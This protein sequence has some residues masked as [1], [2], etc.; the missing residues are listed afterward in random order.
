ME[1]SELSVQELSNRTGKS[2]QSIYKRIRNKNDMIQS[3]LKRDNEGNILEPV[4]IFESAID[5]IYNKGA[6]SSKLN[7]KPSLV[8]FRQ[9]EEKTESKQEQNAY[10]KAIDVL[11]DQL[12][13]LQNE[14]QAEREDKQQKDRLIFELNERLA[15]SQRNLD[16]QQKLQ[17]IDRQRIKELEETNEEI[18]TKQLQ[19]LQELREIQELKKPLYKRLLD[20]F[21]KKGEQEQ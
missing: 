11:Q 17:L 15:E 3:F 8:E 20:K 6:T 7:P 13:V 14:L 4:K 19:Q 12:K 18:S 10:T 5:V 2:I 16:Q 9:E 1:E 21:T